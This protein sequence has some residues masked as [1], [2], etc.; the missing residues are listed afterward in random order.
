MNVL[1]ADDLVIKGESAIEILVTHKE[2]EK[3]IEYTND[4]I[5]NGFKIGPKL[6]LVRENIAD[7]LN[8][9]SSIDIDYDYITIDKRDEGI[10]LFF[11]INLIDAL[12]KP[13]FVRSMEGIWLCVG[14]YCMSNED[15]KFVKKLIKKHNMD[16]LKF[17]VMFGRRHMEEE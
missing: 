6:F 12:R 10:I 17:H 2:M 16:I 8:V 7:I 14:V 3:M 13:E 11:D 4:L 1:N 9:I 5:V 15:Y